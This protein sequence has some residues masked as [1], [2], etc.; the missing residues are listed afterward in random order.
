M[1]ELVDPG[2]VV[3]LVVT[4]LAFQE[5]R[6]RLPS[7]SSLPGPCHVIYNPEYK[8]IKD[9]SKKI[10]LWNDPLIFKNRTKG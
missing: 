8:K 9:K 1:V 4:T 10:N 7:I 2:S 6:S 3:L 5:E